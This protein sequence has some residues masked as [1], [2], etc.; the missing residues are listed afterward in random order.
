[1]IDRVHA[2]RGFRLDRVDGSR[3]ILVKT[4]AST[5]LNRPKPGAPLFWDRRLDGDDRHEHV[6]RLDQQRCVRRRTACGTRSF[7]ELGSEATRSSG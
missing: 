2:E 6:D 7:R 3:A 5:A 4:A 1:M